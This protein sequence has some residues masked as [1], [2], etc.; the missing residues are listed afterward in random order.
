MPIPITPEVTLGPQM[1]RIDRTLSRLP[2]KAYLPLAELAVEAWT[3]PEPVSFAERCTGEHK[4]L[5]AGE[6][7][8]KLWDCGWFHLTG[9]VPAEAAGAGRSPVD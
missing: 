1:S 3:T 6:T 2:A 5:T 9:T 7:W 4:T 8:G